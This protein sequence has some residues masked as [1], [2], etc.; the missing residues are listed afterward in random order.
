MGSKK[1]KKQ[2]VGYRYYINLHLA[3]CHGR[4]DALREI[5]FSDK[6]AWTGDM[7]Y[8][9]GN[10][11]SDEEVLGVVKNDGLFG[12]EDSEGG[13]SGNFG[14][15]FGS[16]EQQMMHVQADGTYSGIG[17]TF[18]PEEIAYWQKV[19]NWDEIR[20]IAAQN[21]PIY[22]TMALNYRGLAVLNF[23]KFYIGT[24]PYIKDM[25][26]VVERYWNDWYAAKAR[27]GDD[28]NPAHIIYEALI[29]EEWGLG[30]PIS[31]IDD[32]SF[33]LAADILYGEGLGLSLLWDA[34]QELIDFI[35]DVKTCIDATFFLN[36]RTGLWTIKLI[37]TGEPAKMILH[38]GNA[39]LDTLQRR[40]LGDTYNEMSVK[41]TNPETEDYATL[42]VQDLANIQSQG[43]AVQQTKE[44]LGVR[45]ASV[46]A[47]LAQRDLQAASATLATGEVTAN[48]QAWDVNPGDVVTLFWPDEGIINM[49]MRVVDTTQAEPGSDYIKLTV[50][51]DVFGQNNASFI[52]VPEPG[53]KPP[54]TQPE[55]F[56]PT[57]PWEFPFWFIY[58]FMGQPLSYFPAGAAYSTVLAGTEVTTVRAENLYAYQLQTDGSKAW[59][60]V[61]LGNVT[62]VGTSKLVIPA[63]ATSV[64]TLDA[65]ISTFANMQENSFV[66]IADDTHEEVVQVTNQQWEYMQITVQRGLMD[67]PP[68]AWPAGV[69]LYFIGTEQMT[70]DETARTRGEIVSYRPVMQTS[71][72]MMD[73]GSVP[74][75]TLTLRGRFD[76]PY[77]VANVVIEGKW[78]PGA[79]EVGKTMNV[80]F[81]PRNR[82]MQ[83]G[84]QQVGWG[85]AGIAPEDGT[86]FGYELSD[87]NTGD[88]LSS[89]SG[90]YQWS[91]D[92]DVMPIANMGV[93]RCKLVIFSSKGGQRN[94]ADFEHTLNITSVVDVSTGGYGKSYGKSYGKA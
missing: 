16:Q 89:A 52:D 81:A 61:A 69:N 58:Q 13:V 37:R 3:I 86:S 77:P 91:F 68:R 21:R 1:A 62:P 54:Q 40:A 80:G 42:T 10:T 83:D 38:P 53:Y 63:N 26:F 75:E 55:L 73:I 48:R 5:W 36:R 57:R 74:T 65:D 71:Q 32:A 93:K 12:G 88:I 76:L 6:K 87:A 24:S 45:R 70:A 31:S 17:K 7:R 64:I 78:W 20:T 56:D 90:S 33:R 51:E 2:T 82:L 39:T 49:D 50:V 72:G 14:L 84:V 18:T 35:E 60:Q 92:V 66:L 85:A 79:V 47:Y 27:I 94:Y 29:N 9:N 23:Y 25:S 28:A 8:L 19:G 67:T 30:Y 59:T 44:Y 43:R 41:Y 15:G 46:A 11:K 34:E 22:P 4:I